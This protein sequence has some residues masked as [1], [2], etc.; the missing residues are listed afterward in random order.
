MG[1]LTRGLQSVHFQRPVVRGP[2]SALGDTVRFSAPLGAQVMF[3]TLP[4][5]KVLV[6]DG[7]SARHFASVRVS[8]LL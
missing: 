2:V 6:A 1:L 4:V 5:G 8:M 7:A 3:S